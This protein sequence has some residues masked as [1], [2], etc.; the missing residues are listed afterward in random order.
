MFARQSDWARPRA[1]YIMVLPEFHSPYKNNICS[2]FKSSNLDFQTMLNPCK[3]IEQMQYP[4]SGCLHCLCMYHDLYAWR[5]KHSVE[6]VRR[7]KRP[8]MPSLYSLFAF[9]EQASR[10]NPSLKEV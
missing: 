2:V 4:G 1:H 7:L 5:V 6:N 8:S 9:T 10:V 3:M